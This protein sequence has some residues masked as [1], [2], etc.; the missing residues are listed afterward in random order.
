MQKSSR[1]T[2]R[3]R[4]L[5]CE[6]LEGRSVGNLW[7]RDEAKVLPAHAVEK[8]LQSHGDD[9]GPGAGAGSMAAMC[10]TRMRMV[11]MMTV[12]SFDHLQQRMECTT[13]DSGVLGTG[14]S[15]RDWDDFRLALHWAV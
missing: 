4:I 13:F 7:R 14:W 1:T 11:V 15:L 6:S 12:L 9:N 5:T 8:A 10:R 2:R 3:T